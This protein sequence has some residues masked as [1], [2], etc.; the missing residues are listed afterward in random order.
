MGT[1]NIFTAGTKEY[2]DPIID[3][4]DPHGLIK[5]RYYRDSCKVDKHGNTLKPMEIITK[6]MKKLI[7]IE[8]QKII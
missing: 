2:A 6:N 3:E 5:G 8:D 1:I 7:I 4:I